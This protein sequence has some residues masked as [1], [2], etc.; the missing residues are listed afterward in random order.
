MTVGLPD[1]PVETY[2]T[3]L[4]VPFEVPL[5][6]PSPG[7]L[8]PATSW[9]EV[10]GPSRHLTGVEVRPGGNYGGAGAFGIWDAPWCPVPPFG[11]DRKTGTRPG[12]LDPFD[13][14]TVWAYDECDLTAPSR[15]EVEA[16][17]AQ[18][19]R[20]EEQVT[21]ERG[22]A[23]RL[24][25]DAAD[26]G[27]PAPVGNLVEAVAH[28]EAAF[29]VTNTLGFVHVGAHWAAVAAANNLLVRSGVAWTTPMGHRW[30]IGGGYVEGLD[31]VL[32]AT[33]QPF[34]WRD[35]VHIRTAIDEKTNTFA[36]VAERTVLVGYEA[37]IG[38]A[39]VSP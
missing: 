18:I 9:T 7:G 32:V 33:S 4:P 35:P 17:A 27:A 16:R 34:G 24:K 14:F 3:M 31:D 15:A 11:G 28:L 8:Y 13:P 26:L 2:P 25:L 36:A 19:M 22:F 38:S 10:T 21:V 37:V 12:G 1:F 6:N 30:V 39:V 29:A 20:L 23:E 5:L